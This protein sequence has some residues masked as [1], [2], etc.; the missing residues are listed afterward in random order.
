VVLALALLLL[1]V[2][3]VTLLL[4]LL[5]MVL[6]VLQLQLQLLQCCRRGFCCRAHPCGLGHSRRLLDLGG[7]AQGERVLLPRRRAR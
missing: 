7:G 1:L 6:R 3:V 5:L 2:V 4:L